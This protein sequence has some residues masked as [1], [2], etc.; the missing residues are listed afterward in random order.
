MQYTQGYCTGDKLK[1]LSGSSFRGN[2]FGDLVGFFRLLVG[3]FL[4]GTKL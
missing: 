1:C 3:T 2:K 4:L